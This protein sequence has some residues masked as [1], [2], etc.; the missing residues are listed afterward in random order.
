[1]AAAQP[2]RVVCGVKA[3]GAAARKAVDVSYGGK[4]MTV[5][6]PGCAGGGR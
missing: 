5:D 3:A 2:F 6:L 1:M 4:E